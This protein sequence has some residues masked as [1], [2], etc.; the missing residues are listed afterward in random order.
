MTL[1]LASFSMHSHLAKMPEPQAL[2]IILYWKQTSSN[3]T[4]KY[5]KRSF[6][7]WEHGSFS[8]AAEVILAP[9]ARADTRAKMARRENSR[10]L[11]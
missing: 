2:Q 11:I 8:I 3:H 9:L 10:I 1:K 5:G 4:I 7:F 6:A